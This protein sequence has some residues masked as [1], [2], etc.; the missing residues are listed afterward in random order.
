MKA[1]HGYW[2]AWLEYATIDLI[3]PEHPRLQQR[4]LAAQDPTQD[5]ISFC[6]NC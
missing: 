6:S 1:A 2:R 3:R 4:P 5:R